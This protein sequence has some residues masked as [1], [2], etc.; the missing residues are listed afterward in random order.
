MQG[1]LFIIS[2]PSGGGKGTLLKAVLESVP[3]VGYSV[4]YTTRK[5]REGEENGRDYFFVSQAEFERLIEAGEFLEYARVHGNL[6]GT[7]K[8]QVERELGA[9]NDIILEI[10]VQGAA[11]VRDKMPEAVSVFILP[12]SF[13]TLSKRL[14]ERKTESDADLAIRLNNAKIEIGA[15][16]W[17]HYVVINDEVDKA[18]AELTSIFLG[19]RQRRDR[20]TDRIRDILNSFGVAT[21]D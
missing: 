8:K 14:A 6:Y 5:I 11:I 21:S 2:S 18:A 17:F 16:E 19:E 13:E 20:Q 1:K 12:P 9:G 3:G 10:D 4:S 15:V 7:S